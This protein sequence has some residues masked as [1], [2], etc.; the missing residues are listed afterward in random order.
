MTVLTES[1]AKSVGRAVKETLLCR[2]SG[3][4][5]REILEEAIMEYLRH[6]DEELL[7]KIANTVKVLRLADYVFALEYCDKGGYMAGRA[8]V[9]KGGWETY[10]ES[11]VSP[12]DCLPDCW[13]TIEGYYSIWMLASAGL[14]EDPYS[15]YVMRGNDLTVRYIA[16]KC[17]SKRAKI[18]VEANAEVLAVLD[19]IADAAKIE[20][21]PWR[22]VD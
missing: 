11:G 18:V 16:K 4:E 3:D 17:D 21:R 8:H 2:D 5:L 22:L 20:A 14:D 7:V 15:G 6:K 12:G 13:L 1:A 19:A 10:L 9:S